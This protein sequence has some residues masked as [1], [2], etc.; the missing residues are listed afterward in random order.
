[1]LICAFTRILSIDIELHVSG[2]NRYFR[3]VAERMNIETTFIDATDLD[4]VRTSM[5]PNT[6]VR[7]PRGRQQIFSVVLYIRRG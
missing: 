1:M 7:L 2:T 6:K 3:K 4:L 5:K